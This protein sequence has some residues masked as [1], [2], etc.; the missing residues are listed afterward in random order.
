MEILAEHLR[1]GDVVK[2]LLGREKTI[3]DVRTRESEGFEDMGVGYTRIYWSDGTRSTYRMSSLI[4]VVTRGPDVPPATWEDIKQAAI[5]AATTLDEL[6]RLID[7][8]TN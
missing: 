3:N 8:Q 2:T 4:E 1:V 7:Q 6:N 5:Q